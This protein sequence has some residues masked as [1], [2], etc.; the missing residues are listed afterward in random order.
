MYE[1][2]FYNPN[3]KFDPDYRNVQSELWQLLTDKQRKQ[4]ALVFAHLKNHAQ[5]QIAE[6][7]ID[8]I[9]TGYVTPFQDPLTGGVFSY[10]THTGIESNSAPLITPQHE[11]EQTA[12]TSFMSNLLNGFRK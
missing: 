7:L 2:K 6:A 1:K 8:F 11:M 3:T 10:F 4:V 12:K 5:I 9:E